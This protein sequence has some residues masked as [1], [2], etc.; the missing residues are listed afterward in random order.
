MFT[1]IK[2]NHHRRLTPSSTWVPD[3]QKVI[4]PAIFLYKNTIRT[5]NSLLRDP[6]IAL[7]LLLIEMNFYTLGNEFL[8]CVMSR[9]LQVAKTWTSILRLKPLSFS[10]SILFILLFITMLAWKLSLSCS[11]KI[12]TCSSLLMVKNVPNYFGCLVRQQFLLREKL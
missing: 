3:L 1:S 9:D 8:T 2:C 12:H 5:S 7:L 6:C 4:V 10:L 11:I